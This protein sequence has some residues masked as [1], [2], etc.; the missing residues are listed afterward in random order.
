MKA[1]RSR[2]STLQ[3]KSSPWTGYAQALGLIAI[4]VLMHAAPNLPTEPRRLTWILVAAVVSACAAWVCGPGP[5]LAAT[6]L[7]F[8]YSVWWL[9]LPL[10]S[11][12]ASVERVIALALLLLVGIGAVLASAA[13]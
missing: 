8:A 4:V 3:W 7:A 13:H 2:R 9:V 12:M 11:N 5:G 1:R 6:T 10:H